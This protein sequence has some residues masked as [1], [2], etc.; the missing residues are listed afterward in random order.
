MRYPAILTKEGKYTLAEFPDCPGCQTFAGPGQD[1][2][3][4]A[5]EALEGWLEASLEAGEAPIPPS[6]RLPGQAKVVQVPVPPTLAAAMAIRWARQEV[7]LS[8]AA[9]GKRLGVSQQA[10][11]KLE[12]PGSNV[13]IETLEKVARAL[14]K[15]LDVRLVG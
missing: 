2:A 15:R 1:L 13:S 8:Q 11:A 10:V 6:A 14:G 4:R 3:S 9:L 12:R 5:G 7:S